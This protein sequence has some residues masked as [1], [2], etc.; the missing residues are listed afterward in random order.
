M[1]GERGVTGLPEVE[2]GGGWVGGV[3]WVADGGLLLVVRSGAERKGAILVSLPCPV[4]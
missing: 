4:Y 2:E 1:S 3:A